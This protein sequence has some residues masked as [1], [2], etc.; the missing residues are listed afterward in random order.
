MHPTEAVAEHPAPEVLLELVAHEAG[1]VGPRGAG[2]EP[3]E[4][5]GLARVGAHAGPVR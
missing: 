1:P 2:V 4:E 3:L 5:G